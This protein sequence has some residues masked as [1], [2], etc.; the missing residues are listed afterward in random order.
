MNLNLIFKAVVFSLVLTLIPSVDGQINY[1]YA[2]D[3]HVSFGGYGRVGVD[4]N[5]VNEG[6]IGR[7]LNLNNMG[8]IGG[9]LEE[10]DYF[11]VAGATHFAP[12][13]LD[14]TRVSVQI[15][16]SMF[17]T[18]LSSIGNTSVTSI[19]GLDIS[20]PEL[21]VEARNIKGSPFSMWVGNRLYRGIDL[22]IADHFYFNDHIGQGFGVEY[23]NTR[24]CAIFISSTDTTSSLPPY[25][26]LNF[27]SGTPAIALRQ[28]VT[29]ALE[30]DLHLSPNHI[31]TLLG[32]YHKMGNGE[33]DKVAAADTTGMLNYPSDYGLVAG[34]RLYSTFNSFFK[35]ASNNFTI[36][37]GTR[38]ANGGDGGISRTSLTFGDPDL[39]KEN[40][41]GAY[42]LAIVND[43]MINL[44]NN[45]DINPYL[46]YTK[47][48]G[49]AAS[50]NIATTYFGREVYNRKEDF[51][52]GMRHVH[53]FSDIFH[54]ITEVH[55]AQRQ[56]GTEDKYSTVK[57]SLAPTLVP[58]GKRDYWA[59]PHI[60]F[61]MSAARYNDAAKDNLY[62]P[63]LEYVGT[64]RW[65]AYFGIKAEWW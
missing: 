29:F 25:F 32:E 38:I 61:V 34:L 53:Y 47:S 62:S 58:T 52:V 26:Y 51:A 60:R 43:L 1:D 41:E 39:E 17:S 15:R 31:I 4:W 56:D 12:E 24:F 28:R 2:T 48:K 16:V 65:G 20:V 6:S 33:D 35:G 57:F 30:Q 22:H 5:Y 18:S 23:K 37:Y 50:D 21:F 49:G 45:D 14:S 19:G 40:Y 13:F 55:Y 64:K 59:R 3:E 8:S 42:S 9:R 27:N 54:F 44:T 46:I 11:E 7:R 63:Y 36:R 10:Q